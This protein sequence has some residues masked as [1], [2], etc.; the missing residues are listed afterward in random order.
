MTETGVRKGIPQRREYGRPH[1]ACFSDR[2]PQ[3]D[4]RSGSSHI[5]LEFHEDYSGYRVGDQEEGG[6]LGQTHQ[7][8]SC[9]GD[10]D[11]MRRPGYDIGRDRVD[12]VKGKR[13]LE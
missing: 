4:F 3:T 8:E 2:K 12:W 5:R 6:N 9:Y 1:M 7:Q 10:S 13:R 11:E